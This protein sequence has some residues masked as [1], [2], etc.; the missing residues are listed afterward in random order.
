MK[1]ETITWL[2][3]SPPPDTDRSVLVQFKQ[4]DGSFTWP[5][6]YQRGTWLDSTGFPIVL[7]EVLAW[8]EMPKGVTP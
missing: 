2:P 4:D 3:P 6:W 8:A 7:T 1:S 5:G